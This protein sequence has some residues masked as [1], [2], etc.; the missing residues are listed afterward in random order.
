MKRF[1]SN[2]LP[3]LFVGA[4]LRLFFALKFPSSS[5]DTVLYDQLARNWLKFG[6]LAMDIAGQ[7]TPVDLRMPGYPAFLAVV[8]A[9]TGRT[10]DSARLPVM[11]AQIFVDLA[12]CLVVAFLAAL[13]LWLHHDERHIQ[14]SQPDHVNSS[15]APQQH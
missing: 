8:Y 5:G 14:P 9:V 15:V 3:A 2:A 11:L 7:P 1:F 10:G 13:D 4:C 12:T 6:K